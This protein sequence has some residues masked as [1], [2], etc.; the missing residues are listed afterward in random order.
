MKKATH[1][2]P[3]DRDATLYELPDGVRIPNIEALNDAIADGNNGFAI[4]LAAGAAFSRKTITR[5]GNKYRVLNHI[6]DTEQTLTEK[7]LL[8]VHFTNIGRAMEA[9]ALF[10]LNN[11]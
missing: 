2:H 11:R 7:Q 9:G 5:K 4:A 3:L 6:D 1:P 10:T 8:D